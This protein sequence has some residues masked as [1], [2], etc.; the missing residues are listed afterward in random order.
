MKEGRSTHCAPA[1]RKDELPR[2]RMLAMQG[3]Y[4]MQ[5][6][7]CLLAGRQDEHRERAQ[8]RYAGSIASTSLTIALTFIVPKSCGLI[9]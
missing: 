6:A 5:N 2:I 1:L 8:K 9:T 3:I 7:A 4:W